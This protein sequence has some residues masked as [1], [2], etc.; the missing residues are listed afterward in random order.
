[1]IIINV[2]VA[3]TSSQ[4]GGKGGVGVVQFDLK[5]KV[6]SKYS[7]AVSKPALLA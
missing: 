1:M 7:F 3:E 5:W 6:L 4:E 2:F